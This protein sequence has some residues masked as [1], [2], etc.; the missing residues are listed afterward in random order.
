[1]KKEF[2]IFDLADTLL[3]LKPSPQEVIFK[4]ILN[5]YCLE[6]DKSQIRKSIICLSN[7]FHYSSVNIKNEL[8]KKDFYLKFNNHLLNMLGIAHICSP[9]ELFNQFSKKK[10]Y[11]VLKRGALEVLNNLKKHHFKIGLISNFN[12]SEANQIISRLEIIDFLQRTIS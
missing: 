9:D 4:Y 3:E 11:W 12:Y 8:S 1:M 2:I 5:K 7:I 6:L 10:S